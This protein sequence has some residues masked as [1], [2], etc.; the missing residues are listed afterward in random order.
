MV[1][2]FLHLPAWSGRSSRWLP[3]RCNAGRPKQTK[4]GR[5]PDPG[6]LDRTLSATTQG[7]CQSFLATRRPAPKMTGPAWPLG[8]ELV[9][10]TFNLTFAR[11][12]LK[13][14][15]TSEHYY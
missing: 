11:D 10:R 6:P 12:G 8:Q 1:N 4:T 7:Q 3:S 14:R 2:A 15:P 9:G 13:I 5:P